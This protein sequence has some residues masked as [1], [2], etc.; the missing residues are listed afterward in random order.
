M[1]SG[2]K[3]I[4][5]KATE[6]ATVREGFYSLLE[7]VIDDMCER[8]NEASVALSNL[9]VPFL[10]TFMGGLEYGV[11]MRDTKAQGTKYNGSGCLVHGLS[12]M[13]D[14]FVAIDRYL[15]DYPNDELHLVEALKANFEGH[16]EL[17][18]YLLACPKFGNHEESTDN[19][20][21]E[22]AKRVSAMIL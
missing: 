19:E 7:Q 20:A 9:K 21:R 15:K 18:R 5:S 2:E 14:S 11:D 17:Q 16:E 8:A 22:I 6:L 1:I 13:A 12:V 10:S 3:L 4:K